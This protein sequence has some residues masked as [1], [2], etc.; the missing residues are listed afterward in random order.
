MSRRSRHLL[1]AHSAI[2]RPFDCLM[3]SRQA[4]VVPP[5][6]GS[7]LPF[8][9]DQIKPA[10]SAPADPLVVFYAYIASNNF[11]YGT[12]ALFKA[13][14]QNVAAA[15]GDNPDSLLRSVR[16]AAIDRISVS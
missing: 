12:L 7:A 3:Q 8:L 6:S 9:F 14:I 4:V 5:N 2:S 11:P 16:V 10:V 13:S 15:T 1:N